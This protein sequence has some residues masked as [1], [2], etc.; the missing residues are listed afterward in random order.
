[1]SQIAHTDGGWP[2][3]TSF[4]FHFE[5]DD[6]ADGPTRFEGNFTAGRGLL[7]TGFDFYEG[8]TLTYFANNVA[9]RLTLL[10]GHVALILADTDEP[11]GASFIPTILRNSFEPFVTGQLHE[12]AFTHA[13]TNADN[14]APTEP[15]TRYDFD[16]SSN[17]RI[18]ADLFTIV[19]TNDAP[20]GGF[21]M[22]APPQD[23]QVAGLVDESVLAGPSANPVLQNWIAELS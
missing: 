17:G 22:P 8:K 13:I 20:E 5:M 1:V 12:S 2:E 21:R 3:L 14:E 16:T 11:F 18:D 9:Y 7:V 6:D 10:D 19:V 15:N 4:S 23:G